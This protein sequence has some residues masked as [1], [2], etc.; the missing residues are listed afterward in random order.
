MSDLK[1]KIEKGDCF[2][3]IEFGSTRIKAV[4]IDEA[5]TPLA[6]GA[7]DWENDNIDG[8]WTYSIEAIKQGLADSYADLKQEVLQKY[9]VRLTRLKA[10]GVSAMMHGFMAFDKQGALLTPFRTWRNN[11]TEAESE[12]LT[13][14]FGYPI[15]QR[16]TISHLLKDVKAGCDYLPQLDHVSTL[17][18]YVHKLL[19][20]RKVIGIGDASGM[21]PID[22]AKGCYMQSCLDKF[23]SEYLGSYSW[24]L[25]AI[26]PEILLAGVPAGT[27]TKEG[28]LLL[29]KS[30][31]LEP[32]CPLC[33]PEGDAGTGMVATN[34]VHPR[35]GNVSAGTSVFAMVVLEKPLSKA[36][37]ALD[38][39]TTPDGRLVAMSH[40]NN[41]TG[42][43]DAW[44]SL[45]QEVVTSLGFSVSKGVLYDT[46]LEKA[47]TGDPDCG[48]V[49]SYGYIS[50]EHITGFSEGR[51]LVVRHPE[52]SFNLA[53][54]VRSELYTSLCA[55]RTGLDILFDKE[56]VRLEVLN[57]H[58]GFFKTAHVG[59]VIMATAA[60]TPCKVIATAGEGGAWGIAILADYLFNDGLELSSFLEE[61]I[62]KDTKSSVVE[63]DPADLA[64]FEVFFRRYHAG[65]SI[66]RAAVESLKL[67]V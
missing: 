45:F 17:A 64:G 14:F 2:L 49:L 39:V 56:G 26:L 33:P 34:S 32:G 38:L 5:G 54:L 25:E 53:N 58:G 7:Y 43:Y 35:T 8:V 31:E 16:W 46:L 66:E 10:M 21:F 19:T 27:L 12:E 59:Q 18:A 61:R 65:L 57:G 37:S 62:F 60:R 47:L 48:G 9:G 20:G 29:D 11:I 28:S 23:D 40:S 22:T 42:S 3:G 41:C 44:F 1:K 52:G 55:M 6:S 50:G 51:P 63:P 13:E 24:K 15:P 36:Y 4:L 67:E 30:G